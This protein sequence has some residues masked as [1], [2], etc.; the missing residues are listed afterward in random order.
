MCISVFGCLCNAVQMMQAVLP[1]CHDGTETLTAINPLACNESVE[2][3]NSSE[4]S[5]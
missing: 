2:F 4:L 1:A 5:L 3:V